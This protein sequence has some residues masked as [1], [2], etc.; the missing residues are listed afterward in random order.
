MQTSQ[1]A[2]A[3]TPMAAEFH[4]SKEAT[5][6]GISL[7]IEGLGCGPLLVRTSQ[8]FFSRIACLQA[9]ESRQVL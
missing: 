7:Y 2:F 3:E 6:L 8:N 5:I 4:V 1:A 9:K